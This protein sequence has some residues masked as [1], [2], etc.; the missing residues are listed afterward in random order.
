MLVEALVAE[1]AVEALDVGVLDGLAGD[2]RRAP[3]LG[4]GVFERSRERTGE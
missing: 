4:R 1:L 3:R 2:Q